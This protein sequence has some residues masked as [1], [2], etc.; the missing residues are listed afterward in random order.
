M[1]CSTCGKKQTDAY[2]NRDILKIP[3]INATDIMVFD[4]TVRRFQNSD[5]PDGSKLF[6]C[7][8]SIQDEDIQQISS[9]LDASIQ[10]IILTNESILSVNEKLSGRMLPFQVWSSYLLCSRLGVMQNGRTRKSAVLILADGDISVIQTFFYNSFDL[11]FYYNQMKE[12]IQKRDNHK[13]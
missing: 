4:N 12:A 6:L 5:W 2:Q 3:P 8:E 10:T 13:A 11:L 7:V 1:A 9:L